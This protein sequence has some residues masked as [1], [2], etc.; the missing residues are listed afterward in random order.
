LKGRHA[1]TGR[2]SDSPK[3]IGMSWGRS[4]KT[5]KRRY[6]VSRWGLRAIG[7]EKV[8][9]KRA[10]LKS[11]ACSSPGSGHKM[12]LV[13]KPTQDLRAIADMT[14]PQPFKRGTSDNL[15]TGKKSRSQLDQKG[16]FYRRETYEHEN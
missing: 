8:I 16:G 9:P 10:N 6:K 1:A 4:K 12:L 3:C 15:K 11:W 13:Q 14:C 7:R 5:E 2:M